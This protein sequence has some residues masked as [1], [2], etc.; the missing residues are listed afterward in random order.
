MKKVTV[1]F[2]KKTGA[3]KTKEKVT[4]TPFTEAERI[5]M[6]KERKFDGHRIHK[7]KKAYNR[8]EKHNKGK[9]CAA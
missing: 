9:Y 7:N 4:G 3:I 2:N 8:K 5:A 6:F 1:Q